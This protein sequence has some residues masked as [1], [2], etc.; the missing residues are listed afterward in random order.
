MKTSITAEQ[1]RKRREHFGADA[2]PSETIPRTSQVA[3][4]KEADRHKDEQSGAD[5]QPSE[6]LVPTTR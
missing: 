2:G 1:A 4:R 3:T 6:R 5:A